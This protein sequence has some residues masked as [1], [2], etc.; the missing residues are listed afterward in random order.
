M[1]EDEAS[2]ASVPVVEL[3]LALPVEEAEESGASV[4][5]V[6]L[7]ESGG[8][9]LLT[10]VVV[11]FVGVFAGVSLPHEASRTPAASTPRTRCKPILRMAPL[12]EQWIVPLLPRIERPRGSAHSAPFFKLARVSWLD[13]DKSS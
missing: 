5:V 8:E 10:E 11:E 12:S 7:S 3:S 1:L 13:V 6:E 9:L 4:P 2:G